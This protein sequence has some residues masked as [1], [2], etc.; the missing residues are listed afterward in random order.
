MIQVALGKRVKK[1]IQNTRKLPGSIK[2]A[3]LDYEE[4]YRRGV[5]NYGVWWKVFNWSMWAFILIFMG[6]AVIF[7]V[8]YLPWLQMLGSS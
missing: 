2:Q 4:S 8:F 1:L 7:F 6:T 3:I 5:E